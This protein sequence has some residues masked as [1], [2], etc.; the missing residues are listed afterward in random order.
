MELVVDASIMFTA[1]TGKGVTKEIIFSDDVKLYAPEHMLDELEEHKLE[2]IAASSLSEAE[3][4]LLFNILKERIEVVER[5]EFEEFLEKA[6]KLL[7]DKDDT[8][9]VALSLAKGKLPIW[10]NDDH[11]KMQKAV[12]VFTTA[13]LVSELKSRGILS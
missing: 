3:V 8:E 12:P 7:V 4:D 5:T 2:L 6:N 1:I 11:F 9:Y 10:S 13:K